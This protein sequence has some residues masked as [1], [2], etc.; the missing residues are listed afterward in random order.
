M[1]RRALPTLL[2]AA[3]LAAALTGC[4]SS[5]N[6]G[7]GG[8]DAPSASSTPAVTT[9]ADCTG[10][11]VTV[12]FGVLDHPD[13]NACDPVTG[14]VTAASVLKDLDVTTAGTTKYPTQV[15]CRVDGEPD[16]STPIAVA[17]HG[18]YTEK[19]Q[20][21]PAAFAYWALW[22]RDSA[23]GTWAY[24]QNGID[25][26]KLKP[27]QSLGLKFTTGSDTTPPEG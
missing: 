21:M 23:T 11:F 5:G 9:A 7:S 22:V 6:A 4:S 15:I 10:V 12:Q 16:A 14:T 1:H 19:C 18:S 25:S 27:G 20:D 26:E 3:A 8:S 17:G 13:L 24:A 2:A